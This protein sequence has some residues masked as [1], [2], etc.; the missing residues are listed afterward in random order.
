MQINQPTPPLE[1]GRVVVRGQQ[2]KRLE[3][4][5]QRD[6]GSLDMKSLLVSI[7][8]AVVLVGCGESQQSAP[9]PEAK[10]E[11]PT[12]KAPNI[13]IHD[14][15][16]KGNIDAV[17]HHLAAG[18]DVNAKGYRGFTPLHYAT[19]NGR[20]EI[21][22]LLI[23][24]GADVNVKIVSGPSIGNTPLDLATSKMDD[25]LPKDKAAKKETSDLLRKHGGKTSEEL[26]AADN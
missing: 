23:T 26:E 18:V 12:A 9:T 25:F 21:V 16:A 2:L 14:A 3:N 24:K 5:A 13:S 8:A 11:P 4:C 6:D 22:E 20:K 19:M 15:A 7:V 17:K 1:R 10:P